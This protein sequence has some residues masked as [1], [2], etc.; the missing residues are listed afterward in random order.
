MEAKQSIGPELKTC[1]ICYD[2][3]DRED[4]SITALDCS[5]I[6]HGACIGQWLKEKPTCPICRTRVRVVPSTESATSNPISTIVESTLVEAETSTHNRRENRERATRE[7]N[8]HSGYNELM[9]WAWDPSEL[10]SQSYQGLW[11]SYQIN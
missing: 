4:K 9:V 6:F 10:Q 1:P 3:M 2:E 7:L 8:E 11:G 5:H